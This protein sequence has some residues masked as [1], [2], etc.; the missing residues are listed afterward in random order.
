MERDRAKR[1]SDARPPASP[2]I[3][4]VLLFVR[5]DHESVGR[6]VVDRRDAVYSDL[7]TGQLLEE[8]E[9]L[10]SDTESVCG[11][12]IGESAYFRVYIPPIQEFIT[13]D[14]TEIYRIRNRLE[15][16]ERGNIRRFDS[17]FQLDDLNSRSTR[18]PLCRLATPLS[19]SLARITR[20][21]FHRGRGSRSTEKLAARE[22]SRPPPYLFSLRSNRNRICARR[23]E[24]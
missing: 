4:I 12:R 17:G 14:S 13:L 23:D 19:L 2:P 18:R 9:G 21:S 5:V 11:A 16:R 7:S 24:I 6:D 22:L 20:G 15:G 10:I 1:G 3:F 8:G